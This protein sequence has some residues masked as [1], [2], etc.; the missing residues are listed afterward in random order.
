MNKFNK[1]KNVAR[2]LYGKIQ[3]DNER[4][5]ILLTTVFDDLSYGDLCHFVDYVTEN[6]KGLDKTLIYGNAIPKSYEQIGVVSEF[7]YIKDSL[8]GELNHY[9]I[10]IRKYKVEIN[11]FLQYKWAYEKHFIVGDYSKCLDIISHLES[12]VGPSLWSLEA[13]FQTFEYSDQ[14]KES[15]KLLSWFNKNSEAIGTVKALVHHLNIRSEKTLSLARYVEGLSISLDKISD[16]DVKEAYKEY[17]QFKLIHLSRL[18]V[19]NKKEVLSFDF[20]STIFDKY[21]TLVQWLINYFL[22]KEMKLSNANPKEYAYVWKKLSYLLKKIDDPSL[23]KLKL[24]AGKKIFLAF[25]VEQGDKFIK[26]IDSYTKGEYTDAK[27]LFA[28][29]IKFDPL[30]FDAMVLYVKCLIY[31]NEIY[32]PI[33]RK[34]YSPLNIIGNNV[35]IRLSG[36]GGVA[37]ANNRL[38]TI[39]NNLSSFNISNSINSFVSKYDK[40]DIYREYM[41]LFS[42][43]LSNPILSDTFGTK[44]GK[45][46]YLHFLKENFPN[47]VTI[48]LLLAR[49]QGEGAVRSF[50]SVIP[51]INYIVELSD[52]LMKGGD[53]SAAVDLLQE[54]L[55]EGQP[56]LLLRRKIVEKLYCCYQEL[57]RINECISLYVDSYLEHNF[58][59]DAIDIDGTVK[60]IN[61]TR[62]S[63]VDKSSIELPIFYRL[64]SADENEIHICFEQFNLSYGCQKP[65]ELTERYSEFPEKKIRFYFAEVCQSDILR[66]SIFINSTKERLEERLKLLNFLSRDSIEQKVTDS[67]MSE[68]KDIENILIIQRGLIDL[69][70]SKIYVNQQ[71]IYDNELQEVKPLFKRFQTISE[72]K[73]KDGYVLFSNG[74]MATIDMIQK[75]FSTDDIVYSTNPTLDLYVEIFN[76][77]KTEFLY[78]RFGIVAYLSTRIRHGVLVGELRPIFEKHK[79][80]TL[81]QGSTSEY[82]D[83][84]YWNAKLNS[85]GLTQLFKLQ[86]LLKSF[87]AKIDGVIFDLIKSHLQVYDSSNPDGWF[88]YDF[89]DLEMVIQTTRAIHYTTFEQFV[90][91][92]FDVLWD[93]TDKNLAAIRINIQKETLDSLNS[94]LISLQ[95]EVIDLLGDEESRQ[96]VKAVND[97]STEVQTVIQKIARWFK[98]SEIRSSDFTIEHLVDV[99]EEFVG[100]SNSTKELEL[101]KEIHYSNQLKGAYFTHMVDLLRIFLDNTLKHS[102]TQDIIVRVLLVAQRNDQDE[103]ELHVIN[104]VREGDITAISDSLHSIKFNDHSRLLKEGKSGYSKAMKIL[105]SDLQISRDNC[106]E[107]DV[108]ENEMIYRVSVSIPLKIIEHE[109]SFN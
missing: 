65:S 27:Y 80:I 97:C 107:V 42:S 66:H 103:L 13:K 50:E 70:E 60:Q 79:L 87:S 29:I 45:E 48:N 20:A 94:M 76:K 17:Y 82:Q 34:T 21:L 108:S 75:G 36:K 104:S 73:R 47:S 64:S 28:D 6:F 7:P 22:E 8:V 85:R 81:K 12:T 49:L 55:I 40:V 105:K 92:A 98:R 77:I 69:D 5:R 102:S 67:I 31:L 88:K 15:K 78:S 62:F 46:N 3:R 43:N 32:V 35:Y 38:L 18:K 74:N 96:L 68:I 41:S 39:A 93:K 109:Y 57:H 14:Q 71:G 100:K 63:T 89:S 54:A 95:S 84:R 23:N 52:Q 33:G 10:N 25:D 86:K 101:K 26:A 30:Q 53:F 4:R 2:A 72:L 16:S 59:V 11:A 24:V 83:N 56:A 99:V 37:E 90:E 19:S 44:Y 106:L 9:L 61:A 51:R 1:G 91:A 58:L